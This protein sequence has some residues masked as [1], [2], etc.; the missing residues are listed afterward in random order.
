MEKIMF[1]ESVNGRC[2]M[3]MRRRD[4]LKGLVASTM[5]FCP[6]WAKDIPGKLKIIRAVGFRLAT[7]R[8]KIVGKNSQ[9]DVHGSKSADR[10]VRLYT[11]MGVDGFGICRA[12]Q[13]QVA[14]LL[15]KNPFDFYR[16]KE[17]AMVSPLGIG[18]MPLW[19]LAGNIR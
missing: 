17:R 9:R 10:L 16:D 8:K 6:A 4:F 12:E 11:N 2:Q 13:S 18:T 15:G 7:K 14:K 5:M 1:C 19:D 3:S